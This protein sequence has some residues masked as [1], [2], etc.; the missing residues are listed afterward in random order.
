[1][2][3]E[4][5]SFVKEHQ[6][7]QPK[8]KILLAFSGGAD[9][10]CLLDL[11]LKAS[12]EVE[13]AHVNFQLRGEESLADEEWVK[14]LATTK[15]LHCHCIRFDTKQYATENRWGIEEAARNLRYNWFHE[16]LQQ[17]GFA[18]LATAHLS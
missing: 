3:H 6:L 8:E 1:M 10:V 14:Q 5:N 12:V 18:K 16:L 15:G 9:S 7:F 11:L 13:L 17:Y 2:F 4:F